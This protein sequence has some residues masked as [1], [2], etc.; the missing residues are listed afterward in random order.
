MKGIDGLK[1]G[2]WVLIVNVRL[3]EVLKW[4][5]IFRMFFGNVISCFS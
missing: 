4:F 5:L 1:R 3:F 2:G